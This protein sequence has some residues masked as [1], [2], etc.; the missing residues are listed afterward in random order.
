MTLSSAQ[1]FAHIDHISDVIL[2]A[3]QQQAS[4][5]HFEPGK[6]DYRIRMRQDGLL[7]PIF[8]GAKAVAARINTQLKVMAQ[9]DITEQRL[10]QDGRLSFAIDAQQQLDIRVSTCPT[11]YGEKIVLRLLDQNAQVRSLD[12]L[13]LL[14]A[15]KNLLQNALS[16]AQGFI[17]VAG[18]TGSGKTT[19]L[20]TALHLLNQASHNI[21]TVE[22]PIEITLPGI[23]QVPVHAKI[24]L[25]FA[26]ILRSLLR[27]DPDIIMIG[28]I[29]DKETAEI[30]IQAAQTGHLVLS[31]LHAASSLEAIN[32]LTHMGIPRYE[33]TST[34]TLVIAQRLLKKK[35]AG[36]V[37]VYECLPMNAKT[38]Q[39]LLTQQHLS[40][41]TFKQQA[42]LVTLREA[43]LEKMAQGLVTLT[44][45]NR[46]LTHE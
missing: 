34:L 36:R 26:R 40:I 21:A 19:T 38:A 41:A 9:L 15:Q 46:V 39:Y 43:A 2:Y 23:N 37:G 8:S 6:T 31:T 25:S 20:Y 17:L 16:Q 10:P 1:A 44:E 12:Q 27:Q 22:D 14:P 13:G 7:V 18:P 33:L 45:I 29:R 5:L 11:L 3:Y 4:D 35:E 42:E 28:E 24:D 30:A 32:R